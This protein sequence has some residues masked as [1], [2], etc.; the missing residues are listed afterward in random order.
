[1]GL[2]IANQSVRMIGIEPTWVTPLDPKSS[3]SASFATSAYLF[4]SGGKSRGFT[5]KIRANHFLY[6]TGNASMILPITAFCER[7]SI[8]RITATSSCSGST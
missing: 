5:Q 4:R 6:L 7:L 3:A 1:M 2:F 8:Q